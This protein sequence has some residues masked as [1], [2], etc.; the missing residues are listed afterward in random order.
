MGEGINL[1]VIMLDSLRR[2]HVGFYNEFRINGK[3]VKTP[4]IDAL[5]K[6]SLV[7]MN[8]ITGGLPTIPIRTQL[9]TGNE[10]L[11]NRGW[12]PL[13]KEDVV[14]SEILERYGYKR[15]LIADTYHLFKPGMN[16]H[17]GFSFD[18]I[19]GQEADAWRT[20]N[21][22]KDMKRFTK[23]AMEGDHIWCSLDQYFR[24]IEHWK[25][26]E[27]YFP[28][29][30]MSRGIE[31]IKRNKDSRF[32]L[33]VDSFD[34]HEPWFPPE[35]FLSMYKDSNYKGPEL[36]HPKYGPVD[37]MTEEEL[38]NVRALY[39]G[40]V[41]FVDKWVGEFLDELKELNLYETSLIVLLSDHGHPHGDHGKIMKTSDNLY[42]E[43]VNFPLIIKPPEQIYRPMKVKGIVQTC[44]ILPTILS[45]LGLGK[46]SFNMG[47]E[48]LLPL[49]KG[50]KLRD[51]AVSG[52]FGEG[53]RVIR[54]E[55]W[56]LIYRPSGGHE[57]YNLEKDP[58]EKIN[59]IEENREVVVHLLEKA[60]KSL[61]DGPVITGNIQE[62]YEFEDTGVRKYL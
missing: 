49:L 33:W 31:W 13:N 16:F 11:T 48:N 21:H 2:D 6:D 4:N 40:E 28:V 42:S 61:F 54:D 9:F 59:L 20:G 56:S 24:N 32:F 29:Q 45:L 15:G 3:V 5:A 38:N 1:I 47:G 30:V 41:S 39:A 18:W 23:P 25:K 14:I 52:Y 36:I 10:T 8:A 60:P 17:R 19:R 26:E 55:K 12:Q 7:F 46:E 44:D 53:H 27:D 37:W 35:P 22:S 62:A 57:L 43:L 34:P 51:V 58:S 50:E